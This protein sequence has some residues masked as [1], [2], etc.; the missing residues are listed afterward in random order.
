MLGT[1]LVAKLYG[2]LDGLPTTLILDRTGKIASTHTGLLGRDTYE[3]EIQQV[4]AEK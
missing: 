3:K 1:E 4:L 2:G